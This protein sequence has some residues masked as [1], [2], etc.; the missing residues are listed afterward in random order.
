MAI[1]DALIR[2][3]R[4]GF[5]KFSLFKFFFQFIIQVSTSPVDNMEYS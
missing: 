4:V 2:E 5:Q 1:S 3:N